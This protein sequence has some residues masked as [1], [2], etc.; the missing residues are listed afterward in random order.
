MFPVEVS[1]SYF[2]L[3]DEPYVVSYVLDI[4]F[5]KNAD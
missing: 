4:T 3:D 5:K 2:H 1:L